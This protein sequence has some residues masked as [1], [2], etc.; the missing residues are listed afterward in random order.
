MHS[1]GAITACRHNLARLRSEVSQLSSENRWP[2]TFTPACSII[3][4]LNLPGFILANKPSMMMPVLSV[5]ELF[6]FAFVTSPELVHDA[7]SDIWP[8][9][10]VMPLP[11]P[12][13]RRSYS[14]RV[15]AIQVHRLAHCPGRTIE[16]NSHC[17]YRAAIPRFSASIFTPLAGW[18]AASC[19]ITQRELSSGKPRD[20]R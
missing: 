8:C 15:C 11:A 13:C 4:A 20:R 2:A 17:L 5:G 10:N 3:T 9:T 14:L 7:A 16:K 1:N 6:E 18:G 12:I 19:W